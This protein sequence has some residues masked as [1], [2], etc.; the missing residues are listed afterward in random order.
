M[1]D[2]VSRQE[3][4]SPAKLADM[5]GDHWTEI[6]LHLPPQ[7][8]ILL[9]VSHVCR[10]WRRL[11]ADPAFLR[12]FRARHTNTPPLAGVFHNICTKD[13]LPLRRGFSCPAHWQ[14][15]DSRQGRVLFHAVARGVAPS[16]LILWDP[17]TRR[18]EQIAMPPN[19]AVYD[20]GKLSGAV[21]CMAGDDADGRHRDC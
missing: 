7:P 1:S 6:F 12:S 20:Y 13:T 10:S 21:V 18:C 19:W 9:R 14:V 8:H 11:A 4:T 2:F 17:L 3:Q 16:M 5:P 15:L